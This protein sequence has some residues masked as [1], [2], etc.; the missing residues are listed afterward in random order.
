MIRSRFFQLAIFAGILSLSSCWKGSI[1]NDNAGSSPEE[2]E[3]S[4]WDEAGMDPLKKQPNIWDIAKRH[5]SFTTFSQ[6]VEIAELEET[7]KSDQ[8]KTVLAPTD[9]AFNQ[10]PEGTIKQLL[11]KENEPVLVALLLDHVIPDMYLSVD[12]Q[13]GEVASTLSGN[14]LIIS[15]DN[16]IMLGNARVTTADISASNGVVHVVDQVII[17]Q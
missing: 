17:T 15:R 5:G 7:F 14:N 13:D 12:L 16:D 1:S 11:E 2:D 8:V 4:V 10:L 6:L 9:E 3:L